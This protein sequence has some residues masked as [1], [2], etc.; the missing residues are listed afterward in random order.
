MPSARQSIIFFEKF[1]WNEKMAKKWLNEHNL[2]P[3]KHVD[4]HLKGELRY[5]LA[6]PKLF[7]RFRTIKTVSGI[8][9]IIGF[10]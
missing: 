10:S 5:R 9:I 6:D 1:G 8:D 4:K 7:K 2:I 3:I